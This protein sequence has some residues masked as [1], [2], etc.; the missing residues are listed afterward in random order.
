MQA[1][2]TA[3]YGHQPGLDIPPGS[4]AVR[5]PMC[6]QPGINLPENWMQDEEQYVNIF[7]ACPWKLPSTLNVQ[8]EILKDFRHGWQLP[9][10]THE[11]ESAR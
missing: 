4:L 3:G 9:C 1:R 7:V 5:C 6:P 10:R 11:H 8:M 2:I